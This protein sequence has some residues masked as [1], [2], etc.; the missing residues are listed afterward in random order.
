MKPAETSF[1]H[2]LADLTRK[3]RTLFDRRVAHLHLTRVQWRLLRAVAAEPG[4]HQSAL[5]DF[6]EME[7]ISVGRVIDR[8]EQG[9][10]IE[11]RADPQDRRRWRLHPT[12]GA[13]KVNDEMQAI[14]ESLRSECL[15]GVD[16]DEM[17]IFLQVARQIKHN[18]DCMVGDKATMGAHEDDR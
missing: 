18:L 12:A 5:A 13:R 1:G 16:R 2:L 14:A 7:P 9:G 15:D 3:L 17:K 8:L 10:F 6:L 4:I 11:R